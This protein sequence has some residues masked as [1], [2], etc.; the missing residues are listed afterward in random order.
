MLKNFKKK[1]GDIMNIVFGRN[2]ATNRIMAVERKVLIIR[3]KSS[4][5]MI[6][7]SRSPRIFEKTS[8]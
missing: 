5:P 8:P 3:I 6:G 2:S 1:F 4:D 7:L